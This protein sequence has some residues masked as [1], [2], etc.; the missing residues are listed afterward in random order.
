[1]QP[2]REEGAVK[3]DAEWPDLPCV[4]VT[5]GVLSYRPCD[6]RFECEGCPLYL[7]L[8]G[9]EAGPVAA[10]PVSPGVS[11]GGD[12]AVGRYLAALGSGCPLHLDRPCSADGLWMERGHA[13]DL[14]FGL[15][16]FTL[17]LLQPVDG[18]VLPRAGAWL[19][20]GAPCAWINRGRLAIVVRCPVA[21]EVVE[22]HPHPAIDSPGSGESAAERW[23]FRLDPHEPVAAAEV[24]R[25]E[26]LLAWYLGRVRTVR[27]HLEAVMTEPT[28]LAGKALADGGLPERNLE[29]VL[30]RERFE[31]LVGAL[32]PMHI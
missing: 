2:V 15:D 4:W 31:A 1:V 8:R 23:W 3:S 5:A 30:G 6:R 32:F 12:D 10:G 27:E 18:V 29:A 16:D 20:H 7:A 25:N 14:R 11:A 17:R 13:G 28:A 9:G 19:G 24:Y 22:V 26:S 21:G